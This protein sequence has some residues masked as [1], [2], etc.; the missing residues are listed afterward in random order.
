MYDNKINVSKGIEINKT[1]KS[2]I[3][4]ICHYWYLLNSNYK[5][6]PEVCN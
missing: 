4:M 1:K 2:E 3:C 5:Y 6:E